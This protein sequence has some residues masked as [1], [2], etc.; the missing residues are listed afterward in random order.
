MED[1]R[2]DRTAVAAKKPDDLAPTTHKIP[3]IPKKNCQLPRSASL[4]PFLTGN[5]FTQLIENTRLIDVYQREREF[6]GAL[7]DAATTYDF[8]DSEAIVLVW[9][10]SPLG[11]T[12]SS[13]HWFL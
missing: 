10:A 8:A 3:Q 11:C 2:R 9:L 1:L 5:L 6:F 4:C 12:V 13:T 7:L